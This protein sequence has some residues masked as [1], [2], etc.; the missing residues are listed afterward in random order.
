MSTLYNEIA[1]LSTEKNN[2]HTV[3]IDV[4]P[5]SQILELISNED[6]MVAAAVRDELWNIEK[7]VNC[8]SDSFKRGG[9]LFYVGAGTSGRLGVLDASECPPTYGTSP[10]MV[11]AII[12]GGKEAVFRS[13][14][15]AEDNKEKGAQVI[16]EYGITTQD[17][18]C[19]I[20]ASGRTPFVRGAI[21]EAMRRGIYTILV[22]TNSRENLAQ[23]GVQADCIIAPQVGAEVIAGS[24][25]MKSG[26][27]Q[28][29]VLNMLT[30]ASMIRIG[31]TYGNVMVDLQL[32]NAKL[33][34]RA[35]RTI[36]MI[37]G[38]EYAEAESV[39][40]QAGGKVKTALVMILAGVDAEEA[41]RRLEKSGGFVR[42][43]LDGTLA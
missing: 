5:T 22:T 1:G 2:P 17:V 25:R 9:R 40:Q 42:I 28:K 12:A 37:T 3:R 10:D 6:A 7:A 38:V 15:G 24:T 26:T 16:E 35:K 39:L 30:T 31:K 13:Q 27:A 41:Q 20:A 21:E 32:T 18:L 23:L 4:A 14:E 11:Q 34:E 43:A 19:G 36:I 8:I 33:S 29:M